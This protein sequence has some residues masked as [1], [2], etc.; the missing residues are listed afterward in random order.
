MREISIPWLEFPFSSFYFLYRWKGSKGIKRGKEWRRDCLLISFPLLRLYVWRE[1][2]MYISRS[3]TYIGYYFRFHSFAS[4][5]LSFSRI[6][7]R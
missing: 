6:G 4:L 1:L 7:Y 3:A 2:G 5:S